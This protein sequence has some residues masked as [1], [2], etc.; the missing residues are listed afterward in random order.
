MKRILYLSLFFMCGLFLFPFHV[1]AAEKYNIQAIITDEGTISANLSLKL[2]GMQEYQEGNTLSYFVKFVNQGDAKPIDGTYENLITNNN[3]NDED[4]TKWQSVSYINST[5]NGNIYINNDWYLLSGYDYAYVTECDYSSAVKSCTM[6]DTPIK[7]EK[8]ALPAYGNR[9]DFFLF[10]GYYQTS[11]TYDDSSISIYPKFPSDG[12]IGAHQYIVKYGK[13]TDSTIIN[14][15][16]K[17]EADANE[18]LLNYAKNAKDQTYTYS[19]SKNEYEISAFRPDF[20]AYYYFYITYE[21]EDGI[22]R[23][24]SDIYLGKFNSG[25]VLV[26]YTDSQSME[27]MS[28]EIENPNTSDVNIVMYIGLLLFVL[29]GFVFSY[30]KLKKLS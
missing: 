26:Q 10:S 5:Q 22:Y 1:Q 25:G 20:N 14:K 9:Y 17:N 27:M 8:P 19:D 6:I 18:S 13:V 28:S 12:K 23:D 21:N 15:F 4:I 24:L 2:N 30:K 29:L 11:G 3:T 16:V 7:V